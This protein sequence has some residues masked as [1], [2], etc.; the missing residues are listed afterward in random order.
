MQRNIEMKVA[1]RV[2]PNIKS[3]YF[4]NI[5]VRFICYIEML[6]TLL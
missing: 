6:A 5:E 2:A 4:I 3:V 1:Q